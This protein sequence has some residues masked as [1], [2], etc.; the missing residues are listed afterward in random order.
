MVRSPEPR[1]ATRFMIIAVI[2]GIERRRGTGICATRTSLIIVVVVASSRIVVIYV[3]SIPISASAAIAV[4]VTVTII[5]GR[6][7]GLAVVGLATGFRG[8]IGKGLAMVG[9]RV[10]SSSNWRAAV[11]IGFLRS[12]SLW[13]CPSRRPRGFFSSQ[14]SQRKL[15]IHLYK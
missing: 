14:G 13:R 4:T 9:G 7:V 2:S 11:T 5:C 6:I 1:S 10:S 8:T 15:N 12:R 3:M